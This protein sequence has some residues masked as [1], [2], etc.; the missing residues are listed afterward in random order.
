MR[1]DLTMD[2][3]VI[4][5]GLDYL[6]RR[7]EHIQAKVYAKLYRDIVYP[8]IVPV[9]FEAGPFANAITYETMDQRAKARFMA[10]GSIEMPL[11]DISKEHVTQPVEHAGLGYKYSLQE[12]RQAQFMGVPLDQRRA[13]AVRRGVEDFAQSVCFLGDANHNLK[14]FLNNSLVSIIAAPTGTWSTPRTAELIIADV[15]AALT[16]IWEGSKTVHLP[17]TILLPPA[18]FSL[19]NTILVGVEHNQTLLQLLK[20]NNI[21]FAN[22]GRELTIMPLSELTGVAPAAAD[23]LVAYEKSPDNE[24]FHFP[25]PLQFVAP[26]PQL[27]NVVVPGEFRVSGV[28]IRY[29]GSIRYLDG[30]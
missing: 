14:G 16:P 8:S 13:D 17:D 4:D 27:L 29:P 28:E 15:N 7:L 26:Q 19:L 24:T 1:N 30:I 20:K 3:W 6:R 11:A 2:N 21:Y 12:L 22:T 23:R 5:D 18:Q 10:P 25:M 9:S